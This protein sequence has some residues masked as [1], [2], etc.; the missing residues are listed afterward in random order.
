MGTRWVCEVETNSASPTR[1]AVCPNAHL[2]SR[3]Q[4]NAIP[5]LM[6]GRLEEDEVEAI[7]EEEKDVQEIE[8]IRSVEAFLPFPP[9]HLVRP[10]P[11]VSP[12]AIPC[13]QTV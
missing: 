6:Q 1:L 5:T 7:I 10:R 9:S 12:D 4:P 3:Q 8:Q 11:S 13:A 2:P